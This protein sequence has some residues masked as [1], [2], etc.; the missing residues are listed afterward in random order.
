MMK[1]LLKKAVLAVLSA[2]MVGVLP[3]HAQENTEI[4]GE[5]EFYTSQPDEDAAK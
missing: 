2:S 3:I 4:K 5:I 1:K